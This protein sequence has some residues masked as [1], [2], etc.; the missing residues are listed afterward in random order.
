MTVLG[1]VGLEYAAMNIPVINASKKNPHIDFDFNIHPSSVKQYTQLLM[2][3]KK[4]K[5]KIDK[6]QIYKYYFYMN[7]FFTRNWLFKDY[8]KNGK[9]LKSQYNPEVYKYWIDNEFSVSGHEKILANLNNFID[10]ND[11]R[12][13]YKFIDIS[14]I[15]D[16]INY[17]KEMKI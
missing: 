14:I 5:I 1:S 17:E 4:I 11:Y 3:P 13:G 16:I 12:I 7:V 8:P 6:L 15:D 10:S 2:N 9:K